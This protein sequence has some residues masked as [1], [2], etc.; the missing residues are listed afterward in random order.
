MAP[1]SPCSLSGATSKIMVRS[2]PRSVTY[3]QSFRRIVNE[4]AGNIERRRPSS[5]LI[6]LAR[7]RVPSPVV[8]SFWPITA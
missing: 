5:S 8:K 2:F 3:N 4:R 7:S 1:G 6:S